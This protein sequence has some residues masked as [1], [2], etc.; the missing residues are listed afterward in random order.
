MYHLKTLF[1]N[2]EKSFLMEHLVQ[3]LQKIKRHLPQ[4]QNFDTPFMNSDHILLQFES[5]QASNINAYELFPLQVMLWHSFAPSELFF[6]AKLTNSELFPKSYSLLHAHQTDLTQN[7]MLALST[8]TGKLQVPSHY[9][10]HQQK[11][12]LIYNLSLNLHL[13]QLQYAMSPY[14]VWHQVETT[15][16]NLHFPN[17]PSLLH[18]FPPIQ[19]QNSQNIR[20]FHHLP[21]NVTFNQRQYDDMYNYDD[22]SPQS[23]N[24]F[25]HRVSREYD[26]LP[27]RLPPNYNINQDPTYPE[28]IYSLRSRT[29]EEIQELQHHQRYNPFPELPPHP[30]PPPTHPGPPPPH[31]GPPP[32]HPGQPPPP[33]VT[34]GHSHIPID[35]HSVAPDHR[36]VPSNHPQYASPGHPLHGS[37]S[38]QR[39][40]RTALHSAYSKPAAK[41]YLNDQVNNI[42]DKLNN[43]QI[44]QQQ[45]MG[46]QQQQQPK[47][48]VLSQQSPN[49]SVIRHQAPT[50]VENIKP[51]VSQPPASNQPGIHRAPNPQ[52]IA[53]PSPPGITA[54]RLP[55]HRPY[56]RGLTPRQHRQGQ[57]IPR[58]PHQGQV[59]PQHLLTPCTPISS[60]FDPHQVAAPPNLNAFPLQTIPV[61]TSHPHGSLS[62]S[63]PPPPGTTPPGALQ[64][65]QENS[66]S[67]PV[68]PN[69]SGVTSHSVQEFPADYYTLTRVNDQFIHDDWD[70]SGFE[71]S[72][73]ASRPPNLVD[74]GKNESEDSSDS[75]GSIQVLTHQN[76]V[77]SVTN[78]QPVNVIK[79][80]PEDRKGK[81]KKPDN[82][83]VTVEH[84]ISSREQLDKLCDILINFPQTNAFS[85][86]T[87]LDPFNHDHLSYHLPPYMKIYLQN[88]LLRL[89]DHLPPSSLAVKLQPFVMFDSTTNEYIAID[90]NLNLIILQKLDFLMNKDKEPNFLAKAFNSLK[91]RRA[92]SN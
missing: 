17:A 27:R 53:T 21:R 25:H 62:S 9:P 11:P 42:R 86:F 24:P 38:P 71:D 46:Q 5:T 92:Q 51:K 57:V 91:K 13:E 59:S 90:N 36:P 4:T 50:P 89:N 2:Y 10:K 3:Y 72:F 68:S 37:F 19:N 54:P 23:C 40:K 18:S 49:T 41:P 16:G 45:Q 56:F 28:Q 7:T 78:A 74:D 15:C 55:N 82:V 80:I 73:D 77:S 34:P 14:T 67:Q 85:A 52:N 6:T 29:N 88:L 32:P 22:H 69:E 75:Q 1:S 79:N 65:G 76:T 63:T 31:P 87:F 61:N 20:T 47:P 81:A 44:Q 30:G 83:S 58:P 66:G 60:P 26:P 43:I 70:Y 8:L 64:Q 84:H 48:S 12:I 35:P 39:I 33:P